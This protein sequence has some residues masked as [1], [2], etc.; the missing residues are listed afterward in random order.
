MLDLIF[1]IKSEEELDELEKG[2]DEIEF[3]DSDEINDDFSISDNEEDKDNE[4]KLNLYNFQ[5]DET[6][7]KIKDK[8]NTLTDEYYKKNNKGSVYDDELNIAKKRKNVS[9]PNNFVKEIDSILNDKDEDLDI[10]K[11]KHYKK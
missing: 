1:D 5:D 3:N 2:I 7:N 10:K 4:D 8:L 11:V 9:F 6:V